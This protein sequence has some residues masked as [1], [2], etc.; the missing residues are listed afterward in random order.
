M[1]ERLTFAK[2]AKVG[3]PRCLGI[4]TFVRVMDRVESTPAVES[5]GYC[6][7]PGFATNFGG[8]A[9]SAKWPAVR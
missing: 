2:S 4:S 3:H 5:Y 9:A 1:T 7:T 6:G 8:A